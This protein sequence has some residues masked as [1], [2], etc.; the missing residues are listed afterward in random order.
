M[1]PLA[2]RKWPGYW[3]LAPPWLPPPKIHT[4]TGNGPPSVLCS[5]K[6]QRIQKT[7]VK[8]M[9]VAKQNAHFLFG[10]CC[11]E[12]EMN[13][14]YSVRWVQRRW[15]WDSS[16]GIWPTEG[17]SATRRLLLPGYTLVPTRP[18]W[19]AVS[20]ALAFLDAEINI[21]SWFSSYIFNSIHYLR[22]F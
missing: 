17:W 18:L 21:L 2:A 3:T 19:T 4:I 8:D 20:R 9:I 12:I 6:R 5:I 1:A 15:G 16:R 7:P 10:I 13:V 14:I 22:V 11:S